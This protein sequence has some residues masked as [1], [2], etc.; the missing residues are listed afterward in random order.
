MHVR[1]MDPYLLLAAAEGCEP[2]LV[3][4][5]LDPASDPTE[6]LRLGAIADESEDES[7]PRLPPR[8]LRRLRSPDLPHVAAAWLER[9]QQHGLQV[10]TPA[11]DGYPPSLRDVALR[12]NALFLRGDINA[13]AATPA[14]AVVGS[15]TPT[16]YGQDAAHQFAH[17]LASAGATLWSGL[18]RGIDAIAHRA[19]LRAGS[20]TIAV[21][22]GGLDQIYPPEH[23]ALAAEIVENGGCLVAELPPGR[24]AQRGHFPRRNR[25]LAA[26]DAVLVIEAG[27]TSGALQTARFS[28]E[29]GRP[30]FAV[31]GPWTSERS[32]GCHDLLREGAQ[33]A[34]DP[35]DLLRDL[36]VTAAIEP[37]T[38]HALQA[39]ADEVALLRTLAL[40]PRPA[41][42]AQRESGLERPRFLQA[43]YRLEQHGAL[44][45]LPGDLLLAT[46]VGLAAA[47]HRGGTVGAS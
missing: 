4:A 23:E 21:L 7:A 27:R 40:G 10:L 46:S 5:L 6:L 35:A 16:P 2:G 24:R 15:R 42:L 8:V 30:V 44:R 39:T 38:A 45:L 26:A 47:R 41:D 22:A 12:P 19:C 32:R 1:G 14:L 28:A 18:A 9:A 43:R 33:V 34:N 31:P 25:I 3:P 20:K 29:Q 13:L 17:A 11:D 36:G 37:K